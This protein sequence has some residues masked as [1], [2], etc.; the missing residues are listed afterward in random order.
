MFDAFLSLRS[1]RRGAGD[2]RVARLR[3]LTVFPLGAVVAVLLLSPLGVARAQSF[4]TYTD[5]QAL[6]GERWFEYS[7]V[8]CHPTR[9]MASPDFKVRWGGLRA[10][11]LYSIISTTMPQNEPGTLS[12]RAY[13]DVVAYLMKINGIPAGNVALTTDST[14]LTAAR[15]HFGAPTAPRN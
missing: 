12:A 10:L 2:L 15:L 6:R 1:S 7:C 14:S 4:P 5:S 3:S 8:T 9:D 13:A 11:D